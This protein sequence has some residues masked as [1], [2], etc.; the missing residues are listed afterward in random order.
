M[1]AAETNQTSRPSR[2]SKLGALLI[3]L[4]CVFVAG[5]GVKV[6]DTIDTDAVRSVKLNESA[7][8]NGGTVRVT[9]LTVGSR[10]DSGEGQKTTT[11]GMFV[12]V[13]VKLSAPGT[14]QS[15]HADGLYSGDW[16]YRP[17]QSTA[18]KAPAGYQTGTRLVFEVNPSHLDGLYLQFAETETISVYKQILRV[19]LGIDKNH[20]QKWQRSAK[21]RTVKASSG[22]VSRKALP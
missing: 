12:A 6:S 1:A 20:A 13:T 19:G 2:V 15:L 18:M 3:A 7:R 17:F 21:N 11:K 4:G 10:L 16:K 8:I 9:Q 14:K 5:I 22:P